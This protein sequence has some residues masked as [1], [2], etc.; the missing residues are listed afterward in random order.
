[1]DDLRA[2]VESIL[3]QR[4]SMGVVVTTKIHLPW[5]EFEVVKCDVEE[6]TT[7]SVGPPTNTTRDDEILSKSM[8]M[9][10]PA[11]RPHHP[12]INRMQFGGT[13]D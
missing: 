7:N 9:L 11:K 8:M 6:T 5:C 13:N 10:F 1:M 12:V 3:Y 4:S 2:I